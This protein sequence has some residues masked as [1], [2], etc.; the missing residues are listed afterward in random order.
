MAGTNQKDE[1]KL[2]PARR[3]QKGRRINIEVAG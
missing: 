1:M 3:Q 2:L